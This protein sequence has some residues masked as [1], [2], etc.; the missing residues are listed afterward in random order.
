[1][2]RLETPTPVP[3]LSPLNLPPEATRI[4]TPTGISV[5][6]PKL[7]TI[8]LM[9]AVV[10][11]VTLAL[12]Q[13]YRQAQLVARH[14]DQTDSPDHAAPEA[15]LGR[16]LLGRLGLLRNWRTAVSIRRIYQQM[17]QAAAASGYPRAAAETPFE[18]LATLALAWPNHTT[19]SKLITQAY[20]NIRYGEF[21]ETREELGQIQ[22][23]WKR[24]EATKPVDTAVA[25]ASAINLT[26]RAKPDDS[27]R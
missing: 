4:V 6:G 23:A 18:Y 1:M 20:V 16:R 10:L 24:L 8:L 13:I 11:V 14:S 9:I 26:K 15:G 27:F 2:N 5:T 7:I 12:G 22:A 3:T 19:E 21:P 17:C 25:G